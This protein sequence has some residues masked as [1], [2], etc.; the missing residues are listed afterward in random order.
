MAIPA[1]PVSSKF[2]S[3]QDAH[4]RAMIELKLKALVDSK[5]TGYN[6]S[7][8]RK[9]FVGQYKDKVALKRDLQAIVTTASGSIQKE[10]RA[11]LKRS[12]L[13]PVVVQ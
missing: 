12:E 3:P 5:T 8:A 11:L 13:R 10:A 4:K 2:L 6:R 9:E 7:D 1:L